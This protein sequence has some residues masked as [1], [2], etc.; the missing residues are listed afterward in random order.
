MDTSVSPSIQVRPTPLAINLDLNRKQRSIQARDS[1][2]ARP[3]RVERCGV[4][5]NSSVKRRGSIY[6]GRER[7]QSCLNQMTKCS[8]HLASQAK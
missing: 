4:L 8:R 5:P 6:D 1:R 3:W 7:K 2:V